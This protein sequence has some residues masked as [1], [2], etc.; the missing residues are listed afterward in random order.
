MMASRPAA[1]L[2]TT[3]DAFLGGRLRLLQPKAGYRAGLDAVLLAAAVPAAGAARVRVLDAGAGVGAA[4]LAAAARLP[5]AQV[6]LV[7]V[8]PHLA[9]LARDNV[10]RNRLSSRV[11]V[12]EADLTAPAAS[13]TAQGLEPQSFDHVLANPP[14]LEQ[15]RGSPPAD[16]VK[17]GAQT[18]AA[19][20]LERWARFL[21]H[22]AA[23]DGT[24][25]L[26]HRAEALGE[27]L[28][29]LEGRFGALDML[30]IHPRVSE[31]AHRVLV[32]G[33]KG[34]RAPLRLL[35]GLVLHGSDHGFLPAVEAILR[36]GAPLMPG[37][38]GWR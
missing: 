14:Y 2:E 35:P 36:D 22:M 33:R 27:V 23:A 32:G 19:G 25:T 15:G 38:G 11:R 16:P 20:G 17:A 37:I 10:E 29:A 7:E 21:A 8:V 26:I 34:S 30:P 24:V 28:A 1:D 13:L 6:T 12:I 5:N 31:P 9:M 18:M 4:G 3:D